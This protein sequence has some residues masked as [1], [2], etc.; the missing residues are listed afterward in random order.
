[1]VFHPI[2]TALPAL[3]ISITANIMEQKIIR[4]TI[5]FKAL[6]NKEPGNPSHETTSSETLAK[7]SPIPSASPNTTPKNTWK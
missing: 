6:R 4:I 2:E 1:M 7:L 5:H 3:T